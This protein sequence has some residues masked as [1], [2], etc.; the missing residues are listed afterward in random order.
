MG[1]LEREGSGVGERRGAGD[2]TEGELR[3]LPRTVM[4][5][6]NAGHS[7]LVRMARH[8]TGTIR[9]P[10]LVP[11]LARTYAYDQTRTCIV[12]SACVSS[13]QP[14]EVCQHNVCQV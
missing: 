10:V 11:Y 5:D 2:G 13:W 6:G 1:R 14:R 4:T 12:R 3:M 9:K 7:P 8:R